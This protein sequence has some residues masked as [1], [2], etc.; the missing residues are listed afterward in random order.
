MCNYCYTGGEARRIGLL[1]HREIIDALKSINQNQE[2]E[3]RKLRAEV[4]CLRV[5]NAK[6]VKDLRVAYKFLVMAGRRA[7][8]LSG[9]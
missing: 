6:I 3:I 4:R 8:A 2:Y 9:V 7:K 1:S 5:A